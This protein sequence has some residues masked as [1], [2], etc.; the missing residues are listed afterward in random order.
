[1]P[2]IDKLWVKN[3]LISRLRAARWSPMVDFAMKRQ[4]ERL[5]AADQG[6]DLNNRDFLSR[7]IAAMDKDPSI[8]KW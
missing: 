2:W 1:M 7:F 6:D 3:A 5:S 4:I 8:P